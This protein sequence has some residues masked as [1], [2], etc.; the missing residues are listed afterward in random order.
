MSKAKTPKL[1]L[2]LTQNVA[3]AETGNANVYFVW[4]E[5]DLAIHIADVQ[6][7]R[8]AMATR[9][10]AN[11][12]LPTVTRINA[13]CDVFEATLGQEQVA[14]LLTAYPN[15]LDDAELMASFWDSFIKA[16]QGLSPGESAA[17]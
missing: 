15:I 17:S 12:A 6:M 16:A 9:L 10:V 14:K 8:W 13:M 5:V 7:G 4:N 1:D 2:P 3:A 11:P